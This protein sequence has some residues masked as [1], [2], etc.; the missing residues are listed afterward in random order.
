[1][2]SSE[3][4]DAVRNCVETQPQHTRLPDRLQAA[5]LSRFQRPHTANTFEL[6]LP[7]KVTESR[8]PRSDFLLDTSS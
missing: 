3:H 2:A 8:R 7:A 1:M 6:I 5:V 4:N